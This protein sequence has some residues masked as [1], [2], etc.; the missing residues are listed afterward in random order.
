MYHHHFNATLQH[1]APP[2]IVRFKSEI[3][4][5]VKSQTPLL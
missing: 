3:I 1:R 2:T 5:H 4:R